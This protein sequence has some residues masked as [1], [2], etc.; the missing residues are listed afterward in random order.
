MLHK[1]KITSYAFILSLFVLTL[2]TV[3]HAKTE[4]E[5]SAEIG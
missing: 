4:A 2:T 3:S 1:F 5:V